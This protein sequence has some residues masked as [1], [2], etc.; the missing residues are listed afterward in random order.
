MAWSTRPSA[1]LGLPPESWVA[2]Q[3]DRAVM[4]LGREVER[5]VDTARAASVRSKRDDGGTRVRRALE[6]ALGIDRA[7]QGPDKPA[8]PVI[9]AFD[10]SG[11]VTSFYY[12]GENADGN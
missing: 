6:H 8:R 9:Y 3:L 12:A 10:E 7:R 11:R 2:Y 5:Q 4:A 1:I